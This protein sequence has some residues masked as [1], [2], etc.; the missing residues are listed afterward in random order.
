MKESDLLLKGFDQ[1]LVVLVGYIRQLLNSQDGL[2]ELVR[3]ADVE[4]GRVYCERPFLDK[5]GCAPSPDDPYTLESVR[6]A[7]TQL[8]GTLAAGQD[9]GSH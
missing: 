2:K 3:D 4:W 6:T 5:D 9:Q 7:L 8:A 1:P